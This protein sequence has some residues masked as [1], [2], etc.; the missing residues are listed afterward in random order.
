MLTE[1][2]KEGCKNMLEVINDFDLRCL[3]QSITHGSVVFESRQGNNYDIGLGPDCIV[4]PHS[5]ALTPVI[6]DWPT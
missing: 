5:T 2:E 3:A 1:K 4:S 6:W